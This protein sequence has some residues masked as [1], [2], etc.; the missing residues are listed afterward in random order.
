MHLSSVPLSSTFHLSASLLSP[1]DLS[2]LYLAPQALQDYRCISES[3][4]LQLCVQSFYFFHSLSFPQMQFITHQA[5]SFSYYS[6]DPLSTILRIIDTVKSALKTTHSIGKAPSHIR[7]IP[8]GESNQLQEWWESV[9]RFYTVDE[10]TLQATATALE[11]ALKKVDDD[12]SADV[13]IAIH[14]MNRK[15][16]EKAMSQT[17]VVEQEVMPD[18]AL[19]QRQLGE[20]ELRKRV[21]CSLRHLTRSAT[22]PTIS[23]SVRTCQICHVALEESDTTATT[24]IRCAICECEVHRDCLLRPA[25]TPFHCDKCLFLLN[26]GHPSFLHCCVCYASDGFLFRCQSGNTPI[27]SHLYCAAC[28]SGLSFHFDDSLPIRLEGLDTFEGERFPPPPHY[29]THYTETA[30]IPPPPFAYTVESYLRPPTVRVQE[31]E[32][33]KLP[34]G[35]KVDHVPLPLTF[36]SVT[37]V[38]PSFQLPLVPSMSQSVIEGV[39]SMTEG[40]P[41]MTQSVIEGVTQEAAQETTQNITLDTPQNI[42]QS[43]TQGTP[44]NTT[45]DTTQPALC[46]LCRLPIG[47]TLHCAYPNCPHVFHLRCLWLTG[48]SVQVATR[49]DSDPDNTP[50]SLLNVVCHTHCKESF[51]SLL[52]TIQTRNAYRLSL[53]MKLPKEFRCDCCGLGTCCHARDVPCAWVEQN[54]GTDIQVL[55]EIFSTPPTPWNP[56]QRGARGAWW[57]CVGCGCIV[58]EVCG[59]M[60][61]QVPIIISHGIH[62]MNMVQ[63]RHRFLLSSLPVYGLYHPFSFLLHFLLHLNSFPGH[64]TAQLWLLLLL[65]PP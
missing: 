6:T 10:K 2:L 4:A 59:R 56:S 38:H 19:L 28:H 52:L 47:T 25:R 32:E 30:G 65:R 34:A 62:C 9:D 39:P 27:F 54:K 24:T 37:A 49:S 45:Q 36:A 57:C 13:V 11:T 15:L 8:R 63:I 60:T 26:G 48:G 41:S 53:P 42:S 29:K 43:M 7:S 14:S 20:Y 40:V 35:W 18:V 33:E 1:Y 16:M 51:Q 31:K 17:C 44:Q 58:H 50:Q 46:Y 23:L 64:S 22:C 55:N 5:A 12:V 21:V 61:Q 3:A